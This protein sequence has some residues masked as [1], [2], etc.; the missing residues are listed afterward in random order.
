[1]KQVANVRAVLVRDDAPAVD[2]LPS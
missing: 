2:L 1:M